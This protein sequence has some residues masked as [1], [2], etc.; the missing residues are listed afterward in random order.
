AIGNHRQPFLI[1][2]SSP[3]PYFR[4]SFL[5]VGLNLI[6]ID[7]VIG[8]LIDRAVL[9]LLNKAFVIR[10]LQNI[11]FF[12]WHTADADWVEGLPVDVCSCRVLVFPSYHGT[13]SIS[14]PKASA[15][16][17]DRFDRIHQARDSSMM[18]L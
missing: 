15:F 3:E 17:A 7:P 6:I 16:I 8:F 11:G 10:V 13:G 12:N 14:I 2:R 9:Y 18:E 4:S 1:N 5:D